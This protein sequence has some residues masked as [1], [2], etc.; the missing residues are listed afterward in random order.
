[1]IDTYKARVSLLNQFGL[2]SILSDLLR[3]VWS[4]V[5]VKKTYLKENIHIRA[6]SPRVPKVKLFVTFSFYPK[7]ILNSATSEQ[8][9]VSILSRVTAEKA[10]LKE[11]AHIRKLSP[12]ALNIKFSKHSCYIL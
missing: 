5:T 8:P 11:N 2:F 7:S 10:Y 4:R 9:Y 6:F 12:R 3:R 1:M